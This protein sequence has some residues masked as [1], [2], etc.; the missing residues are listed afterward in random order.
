MEP[1]KVILLSII[2]S[3]LLFTILF[4][5]IYTRR[6]SRV[7]RDSQSYL[8]DKE[9]IEFINGQPDKI[10]NSKILMEEFGIS[11]FDAGARLRNFSNNGILKTLS[12]RN[13][14][15]VY[16]MLSKP[17]EKPYDLEL[18]DDAFMT[19][20]DLMLIFKYNDYQVT[21]QEICLTTGLPIKI[22]NEEMK[23]F[24]KENVIKCLLMTNNG[25]FTHQRIY[26]LC[27]PYRSNPDQF[28]NLKDVNYE[29]NE[30][31]ENVRKA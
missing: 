2:V 6:T 16:Y 25:G 13:G 8:S 30:I 12:T 24:E 1:H 29:L 3:I 19:V 14:L 11:K 21:L 9:L 15:S 31:Y 5:I 27:E 4:V 10:V 7:V 17:I 28:L 22:I 23:F 26:T 20:E 18:T